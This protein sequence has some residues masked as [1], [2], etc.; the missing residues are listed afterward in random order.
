M[1]FLAIILVYLLVDKGLGRYG[2]Q[3][4]YV[5]TT[6]DL[7]GL[8]IA[9]KTTLKFHESRI[10]DI[11]DTWFQL[12]PNNIYFVT[13]TP[14]AKLNE[15]TGGKLIVSDCSNGHTRWACHFDDDNYVNIAELVRVLKK[16]DPKRDWYLGRPSTVGPVGID[17]IPEKA[18]FWFA[19]GGA[20]FC[21]SKSLLAKMSSYVRNGGFEELGELLRLPDDVSLGYL[22]G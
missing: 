17:S 9:V 19:T 7:D 16:L 1:A 11:I 3:I 5:P 2:S 10:R 14:D 13:D 18:T 12:A 8:V 20:G 21:L 15:I 6:S 22:I 4:E